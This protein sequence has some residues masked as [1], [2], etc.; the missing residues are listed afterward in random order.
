VAGCHF[1]LDQKIKV[2]YLVYT[3]LMQ[4]VGALIQPLTKGQTMTAIQLT[5]HRPDVEIEENEEYR[6]RMLVNALATFFITVLMITGFWVVNT[7][8]G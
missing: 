5:R 1:P 4:P 3:K 8:A 7:L 2:G 6:H